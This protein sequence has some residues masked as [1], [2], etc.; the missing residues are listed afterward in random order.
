M[1]H[2]PR[3]GSASRQPDAS[4]P[5]AA[6]SGF[7][8]VGGA[9]P[10]PSNR[11]SS[12]PL[13]LA[14]AAVLAV[15]AA[16]LW[17]LLPRGGDDGASGSARPTTVAAA[18]P[19]AGGSTSATA[20]GSSETAG[21]SPSGS[22]GTPGPTGTAVA[23]PTSTAAGPSATTGPAPSGELPIDPAVESRIREIT[24]QVPP[25]RGLEALDDVP[26]RFITP[27]QFEGELRDLFLADNPPERVAAE[28]DVLKRLGLLEPEADLEELVLELYGSQVA[29]FY[30]TRTQRFTVIQRDESAEFG[31]SDAIVVAHEYVHALQDQHFDLEGTAVVDPAEGDRALGTL[32][33]IEGDAVAVMID[34]AIANLT[35]EELLGIQEAVTPADQELL[36]SMPPVLRRQL[37]FPYTDGLAFVTAIRAGGGYE[38]VDAAFDARPVSTEQIMH[39]EK[40]LEREDPIV[41][42]LPD[43]AAALGQGWTASYQQTLGELLIGVL[44]ADGESAPGPA[45][46]GLLPSLPNAEAAAGW[47][48]D[49][50][51]SLDGP[52][53]AWAVYWRTTWD[54]TEDAREFEDSTNAALVDLPFPHGLQVVDTT[55]PAGHQDDIYVLIASDEAT[56]DRLRGSVPAL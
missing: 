35:F 44:V 38:A 20:P 3:P 26:F 21:S 46:P 8:S 24:D 16:G 39:P 34:W 45:L 17:L 5:S 48:G 56:L 52:D 31:P 27:D 50:L 53:G 12:V 10:A 6:P 15:L 47:G 29:A 32:G 41:V 54:S 1:T 33:L 25:I 36:E 55:G 4:Q 23:S 43:V 2:E 40:Y 49:R 37:E 28:E 13:L 14:A 42:E 22:A 19:S 18:S 9:A 7:P 51:V 30:D 11:G